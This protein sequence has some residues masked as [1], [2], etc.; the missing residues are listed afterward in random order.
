MRRVLAALLLA[1]VALVG[2]AGS[3]AA[4][5]GPDVP[6]PTNPNCWLSPKPDC[7]G[8]T[9]NLVSDV[10]DCKDA[11]DPE[12][13]GRGITGFFTHKPD[14]LPADEDPFADGARV[15]IYQVYGY[16]GL[17]FNTYDLG[18]GGD[19]VRNPDAVVGNAI[20][21]WIF[22]V[23]KSVI[24]ATA[25]LAGAA[26]Q[27]EF[28]TAFNP[29]VQNV[30]DALHA[31]LFLKWGWIAVA[32][33]GGML[34]YNSRKQ[35]LSSSAGMVGWV[36]LVMI[37]VSAVLRW[38]LAAGEAADKTS[39]AVLTSVSSGITG[40]D[41]AMASSPGESGA[42]LMHESVLYDSWLSGTFG[43]SDSKTAREYGPKIFAAT[44]LT[45]REAAV[46]EQDPDEGKKIIEE[47]KEAFK[48]LADRLK[49]ED[50]DAYA[51]L[52][53]KRSDTRVG[54]TFLAL[55]A[56]FCLVPFLFMAALL[57]IGALI[58]IRVGVM[59][60]P[61]LA[62]LALFHQARGILIGIGS[63]MAAAMVNSL[64]FG[65]MSSV[66]ILAMGQLMVSDGIPAGCG[67]SSCS[68]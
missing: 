67:S 18:C 56:A 30:V 3:A 14:K 42:S 6:D 17:R 29:L 60:T 22:Q 38:P 63:T 58:I 43:S 15:S 12:V 64:V 21:N 50:P 8:T 28:L 39:A 65:S 4:K 57:V 47:K 13:P 40:T 45:W 61:G 48:E 7:S 25:A 54:F 55:A 32:L 44:A 34:I 19:I 37:V 16:A 26:L 62:T 11:P 27:P 35:A 51:N 49:E 10:A 66:F 2:L 33:T 41:P 59:V 9:D 46:L 5:D 23:P 68:C 53:G 20:A 24:S 36:L 52:S 1:V 31:A